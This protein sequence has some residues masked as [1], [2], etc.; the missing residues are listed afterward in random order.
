MFASK[1]TYSVDGVARFT[2]RDGWTQGGATRQGVWTAIP[3]RRS[4]TWRIGAGD[5]L[6]VEGWVILGSQRA[7]T[8]DL[9]KGMAFGMQEVQKYTRRFS[10]FGSLQTGTRTTWMSLGNYQEL[11]QHDPEKVIFLRSLD[12]AKQAALVL[13][14]YERKINHEKL[15]AIEH[16]FFASLAYQ[17]GR[18][19]HFAEVPI[20]AGAEQRRAA[21]LA[22][23]NRFLSAHGLPPVDP[24]NQYK[25][26]AHDGWVYQIDAEKFVIGRRLGDRPK[27]GSVGAARGELGWLDYEDEAWQARWPQT[28]TRPA[29]NERYFQGQPVPRGWSKALALDT[30]RTR[31]YFFHVFNG[32]LTPE[33]SSESHD[34]ATWDLDGWFAQAQVVEK[35]FRAGQLGF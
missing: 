11:E 12:P 34:P 2:L 27:G 16:D 28:M 13:R 21:E 6:E 33:D 14:V 7:S 19:K 17:Q 5:P 18:A 22:Y 30:D 25:I 3:F 9:E 4:Q 24:H 20:P 32:E 1:Q 10:E 31:R 15:R 8:D 35:Q 26:Q 23:I 29:G